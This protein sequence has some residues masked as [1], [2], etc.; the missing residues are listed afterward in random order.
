MW[1]TKSPVPHPCD[2][3]IPLKAA[4]AVIQGSTPYAYSLKNGELHSKKI[5]Y[6][7]KK[8]QTNGSTTT[9]TT[10]TTTID[11]IITTDPID[12]SLIRTDRPTTIKAITTTTTTTTNGTIITNEI[13]S[14][15]QILIRNGCPLRHDREINMIIRTVHFHVK[16]AK[17]SRD[18]TKT[19]DNS[20]QGNNS[21]RH[22][23]PTRLDWQI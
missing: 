3:Q 17:T 23:L 2:D 14:S 16:T 11:L 1:T 18:K 15:R 20:H 8:T 9:T 22:L 10:T 13:V 4:V 5:S 6:N 12:S 21:N 7:R 19:I